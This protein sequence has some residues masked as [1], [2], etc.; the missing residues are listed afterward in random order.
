MASASHENLPG[1]AVDNYVKA[2]E[3]SQNTDHDM[4]EV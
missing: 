3:A 2:C 1:L 4:R